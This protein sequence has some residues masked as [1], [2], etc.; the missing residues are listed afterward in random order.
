M[1]RTTKFQ[2]SLIDVVFYFIIGFH[3]I[4]IVLVNVFAGV[5]FLQLLNVASVVLDAKRH[6]EKRA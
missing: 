2:L 5:N 6:V 1:K 4:R 3:N